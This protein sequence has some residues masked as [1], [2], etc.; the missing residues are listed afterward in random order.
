[1]LVEEGDNCASDLL[2]VDFDGPAGKDATMLMFTRSPGKSPVS[3]LPTGE[4]ITITVL[5]INNN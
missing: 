4:R 5:G 3:Q 2:S 1:L